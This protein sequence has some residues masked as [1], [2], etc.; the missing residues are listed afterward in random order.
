MNTHEVGVNA[1]VVVLSPNALELADVS[2]YLLRRG[3]PIVISETRLDGLAARLSTATDKPRLVFFAFPLEAAG[4]RDWLMSAINKGW[5]IVLINGD[6]T[7][8]EL[9]SLPMLSRPFDTPHLDA[10][11]KDIGE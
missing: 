11:M 5:R 10:L 9:Q 6:T 7:E 2:D 4:A 3:F 8:P 1:P